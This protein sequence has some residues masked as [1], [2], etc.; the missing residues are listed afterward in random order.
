VNILLQ[1]ILQNKALIEMFVVGIVGVGAILLTIFSS[2]I[3]KLTNKA[4]Q[5]RY[6]RK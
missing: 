3:E 4:K 1:E 2:P 5:I 6:K